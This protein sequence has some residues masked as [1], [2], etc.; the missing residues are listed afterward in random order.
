MQGCHRCWLMFIDDVTVDK[1][2]RMNSK[3]YRLILCTQ[4][5]QI[6]SLSKYLWNTLHMYTPT[7]THIPLSR[8]CLSFLL[9]PSLVAA[10]NHHGCGLSWLVPVAGGRC[11][12]LVLLHSPRLGWGPRHPSRE[13]CISGTSLA[14][15]SGLDY[16]TSMALSKIDLI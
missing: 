16:A 8:V 10:A 4:I 5:Q 7:Y 14:F 12:E 9:E 13:Q 3:V 2:G 11:G 15:S 1:S 6:V